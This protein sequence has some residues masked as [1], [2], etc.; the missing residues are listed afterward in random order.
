MDSQ[1]SK[2]LRGSKATLEVQAGLDQRD[3][4]D[5]RV[6]KDQQVKQGHPEHPVPLVL[7]APQAPPEALV[8]RAI[9]EHQDLR[10]I[11]DNKVQPVSQSPKPKR[12]L[13][14]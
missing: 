5:K 8:L 1:D 14:S 11:T 9:R 13:V 3:H 7:P 12:S 10:E 2:D 4:L 6:R